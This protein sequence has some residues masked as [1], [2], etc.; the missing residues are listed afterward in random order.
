MQMLLQ[1]IQDTQ[2]PPA[3]MPA[4]ESLD[5]FPYER[6]VIAAR[7]WLE[8]KGIKEMKP[9]YPVAPRVEKAA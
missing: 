9:L 7:E 3:S 4:P 2:M 6:K 1:H 8:A 5:R